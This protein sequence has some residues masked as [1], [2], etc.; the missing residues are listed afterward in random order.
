LGDPFQAPLLPALTASTATNTSRLFR[1]RVNEADLVRMKREGHD[2]ETEPE[3]RPVR[4]GEQIK[5]LVRDPA[6]ARALDLLKGLNLIK[7][8]RTL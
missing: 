1:P 4:P 6:L 2:L 8:S 3:A 5:N 7:W